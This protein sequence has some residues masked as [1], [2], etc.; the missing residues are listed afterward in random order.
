[1][2]TIHPLAGQG[3]NM[4]LRDI[5][6]FLKLIDEKIKYGL[7]L[8]S[9]ILEEFE[10]NSAEIIDHSTGVFCLHSIGPQSGYFGTTAKDQGTGG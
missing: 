1:M 10:K 8:D 2:H 9:S 5:K 3:F 6:Y 4:T 7:N